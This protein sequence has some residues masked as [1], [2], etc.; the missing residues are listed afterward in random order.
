MHLFKKNHAFCQIHYAIFQIEYVK[1][2]AIFRS[3]YVAR[4]KK[5]QQSH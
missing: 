2:N 4:V 1:Y 5:Q 3:Y